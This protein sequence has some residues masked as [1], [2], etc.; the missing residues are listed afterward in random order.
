[1]LGL[2]L[3][4]SKVVFQKN[5]VHTGSGKKDPINLK[6]EIQYM[7]CTHKSKKKERR[8]PPWEKFTWQMIERGVGRNASRGKEASE[9]GAREQAAPAII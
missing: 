6:R 8:Q 5:T 1:M 4:G 3:L 2:L 9:D 7:P